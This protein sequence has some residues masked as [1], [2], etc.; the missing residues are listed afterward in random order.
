MVKSPLGRRYFLR[1]NEFEF[2][3]NE[4]KLIHQGLFYGIPDGILHGFLDGWT[5]YIPS[6]PILPEGDYKAVALMNAY[7]MNGRV[8]PTYRMDEILFQYS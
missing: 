8:I 3:P 4:E 7:K 2:E 1:D 6:W 5:Q